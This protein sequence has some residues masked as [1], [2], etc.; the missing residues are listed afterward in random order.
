MA[1]S[2]I[3]AA[4]AG[5]T[6]AAPAFRISLSV[7]PFTELLLEKGVVFTDGKSTARTDA[8]L[9]R[10]LMNHGA[11]E[12]Y[13]R[14]ATARTKHAGFGDHSLQRGLARA[15]LAHSLKLPFNPEIGLFAA[16]GTTYGAGNGSTTFNLPDLRGRV[17]AGTDQ[18]AGRLGVAAQ[19]P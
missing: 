3:A 2:L 16:Y 14:I 7:S 5:Q 9:Q 8:E 12:V 11:N 4:L 19:D 10:L 17:V 13:A 15:R 18:G 6:G 1:T